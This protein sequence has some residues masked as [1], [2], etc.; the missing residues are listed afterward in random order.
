MG[1]HGQITLEKAQGARGLTSREHTGQRRGGRGAGVWGRCARSPEAMLVAKK[2]PNSVLGLYFGKRPLM[3][4]LKAKL[5]ACVGKYRITL[6][7]LPR[8]KAEK[9]CSDV[10]R[11][12]QSTMPVYRLTSPEMILG[13]ASW[14]WISSFTRSIGAVHVLATAPAVPPAR[15]SFRK[16]TVPPPSAGAG[17]AK[18]P[19]AVRSSRF[20]TLM[21]CIGLPGMRR[22]HE[23]EQRKPAENFTSQL[24]RLRRVLSRQSGSGLARHH[25]QCAVVLHRG[26]QP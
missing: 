23:R 6:T 7:V 20:C 10:T 5:K 19:E 22:A 9:P 26:C 14:V 8:Q 21:G 17:A 13:L 3:V 15:K 25:L 4:S 11:V 1:M 2:A 18:A 24:L 12:K 16:A